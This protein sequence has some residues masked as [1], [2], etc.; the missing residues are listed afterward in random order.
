MIYVGTLLRG[1]RGGG[2]KNL[3]EIHRQKKELYNTQPMFFQNT[4]IST[5]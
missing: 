5:I 2:V 4:L 3:G 1:A